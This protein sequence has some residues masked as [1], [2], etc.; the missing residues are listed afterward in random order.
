MLKD[1]MKKFP[2]SQ[3]KELSLFGKTITM[4]EEEVPALGF[5]P[6]GQ[7]LPSARF[8][9]G[10]NMVL[11]TP[12]FDKADDSWHFTL[13]TLPKKRRYEQLLFRYRC[14]QGLCRFCHS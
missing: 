2:R 8:K 1:I 5:E 3:I 7:F 10:N 9:S 6:V 12:D 11:E 14:E 13:Y 4:S